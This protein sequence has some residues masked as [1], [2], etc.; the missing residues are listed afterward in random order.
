[1]NK[2]EDAKSGDYFKECILDFDSS[3]LQI[4]LQS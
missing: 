3:A 4:K 1:M 2:G